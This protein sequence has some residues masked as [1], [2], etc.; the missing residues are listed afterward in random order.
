MI[1]LVIQNALHP[2]IAIIGFVIIFAT[3]VIAFFAAVLQQLLKSALEIKA[4]NDLTI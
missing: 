2:G 1:L 3:L 4:E